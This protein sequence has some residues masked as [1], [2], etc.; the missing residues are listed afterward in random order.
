MKQTRRRNE[1]A[2]T[3]IMKEAA[4]IKTKIHMLEKE[5]IQQALTF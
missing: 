2:K 4:A 5:K 3:R 1:D